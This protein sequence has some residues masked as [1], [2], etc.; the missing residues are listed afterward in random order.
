[1][2][3]LPV[4]PVTNY[5]Q[6][7]SSYGEGLANQENATTNQLSARAQLPNI[8]ANTALT[9]AQAQGAD[10]GNQRAAT[11]LQ[12][13]HQLMNP[14]VVNDQSPSA[15]ASGTSPAPAAGGNTPQPNP[16]ATDST[17]DDGD[18]AIS[19]G[20]I[21]PAHITAGMQR[22]FAVRDQWTPDELQKL[23]A[24]QQ[25][26]LAG[27]PNMTQNVK[28]Q[29]DARIQNL[30]NQ[31]QLGASRVYDQ[32]YAVSTAP[33]GHALAT[34]QTI[35]PEAA[36]AIKKIAD[37]KGWTADQTDQYA[38]TLADEGGNAAHRYSG[39]AIEVGK[40]GVA[41]DAQT[42]QPVL[43]GNPAGLTPEA[44]A[45]LV[46]KANALT[47]T[48]VNGVTT[49]VPTWQAAG[50]SSPIAYVNAAGKN[51]GVAPPPPRTNFA[52]PAPVTA[53]NAAPGAAA[54][55]GAD[56]VM[57]QA[58]S[59]PDYK[60]MP[61]K[62]PP[63]QAMDPDSS[64][65]IAASNDARKTLLADAQ[66]ATKAAQQAQVYLDAAKAITDA[67]GAPLGASAAIRARVSAALAG[68]P[69]S[70][71]V[72]ATNYQEA[73]KYL[74]N[75][76]IQSQKSNFPNATQSEVGLTLN[77]LNPSPKMTPQA[78]GDLI[79]ENRRN[80]Q[81]TIDSSRRVGAYLASGGDPQKF[82]DWNGKY[83]NQSKAV[84][85]PAA[86]ASG[87]PVRVQSRAQAMAL[88]PGTAF[89]TPDGRTLVR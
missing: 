8:Q 59:D 87:A 62:I 34:L 85:A 58:L 2:A 73:V 1:M 55:Q 64:A 18:L 89:I 88:K 80:T 16:A 60:Y 38:R 57:R 31:A 45:E 48:Y 49:K 82:N 52:R 29:H 66:S 79:E 63:G 3:D 83:F 26:E 51:G 61:P 86:S 19:D 72:D 11:Q 40:D 44:H 42:N 23:Q 33:E 10:I 12:F 46:E 43:G 7:L 75:A 22:N 27:L 39:R 78:V 14:P 24:A 71:G 25:A 36:A 15:N 47:D 81:Y 35:H 84:N 32:A 9:Q 53:P 28:L 13:L 76:A 50:F 77:E 54:P 30:T 69:F 37:A 65:K 74:G 21:D 67:G 68:T 6:M 70:S 41:R 4:L 20:G 5:G 56:L 17:S